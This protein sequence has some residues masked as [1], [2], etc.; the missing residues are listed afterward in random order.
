M[1]GACS[2]N[3]QSMAYPESGCLKNGASPADHYVCDRTD[4]HPA[5]SRKGRCANAERATKSPIGCV[6]RLGS[7]SGH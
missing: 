6:R 5:A 1:R 4:L 3:T 2:R 7:D